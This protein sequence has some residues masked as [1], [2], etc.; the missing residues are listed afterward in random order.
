MC[1]IVGGISLSTSDTSRWRD[2][3]DEARRSLA[4]RGPD[5]HGQF[6]EGPVAMAHN[7]LKIIDLSEGGA[8]PMHDPTGRYVLAFNGEVFNYRELRRELEQGGVQFT[9][10]SDTEVMLALLIREGIAALPKF[11]G[12][13][14]LAF[15]DRHTR[16]LVLA[17]DPYGIKPLVLYQ[18]AEHLL[19]ASELK[20]LVELGIPRALDLTALALYTQ[21]N[22]VPPQSAMLQGVRKLNPGTALTIADVQLTETR[23]YTL[24]TSAAPERIP[25]YATATKEVRRRVEAAV[26]RRMISDV[27]VGVFLS[28]GLDSSI[29]AAV[30]AR[31]TEHLATFSLGFTDPV[32][33]ES[34]YARQVA[35]HLGTEHTVLTVTRDTLLE[36][37][38]PVLDYLDEPFADAAA[39]NFY[40]LS[41]YV[42][43]HVTVALTG[44]G[45]DEIF[46][47]YAK[48]VGESW[49][50]DHSTLA[51]GL[52][53]LSG[54]LRH[55]PGERNSQLGRRMAQVQKLADACTRSPAERYWAW[56]CTGTDVSDLLLHPPSLRQLAAYK[57]PYLAHFD[58]D[59]SMNAVYAADAH[60][61]L[62]G[63]MLPKA[64][65]MSM[66]NSLEVRP[67]FLDT[68]VVDYA[69]QLP[70]YYKLQGQ[71][72]KR[73][74]ADAFGGTLP[75][76]IT[77]RRKQGFEVPLAEWFRTSLRTRIE[78]ELIEPEFLH[79]QNLFEPAAVHRLW[80]AVLTG[81][82]RKE[83]WT[84][85]ALLVFQSFYRR[86]LLS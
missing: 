46:G 13:F 60:L 4:L 15:Y 86:Y 20:A 38:D 39:L 66:A 44:D 65:L 1:G 32:Y 74:L 49:V 70:P 31:H 33:D 80:Q 73:I 57:A 83:D 51:R 36:H 75:A 17:R 48:H 68:E 71:R 11:N 63:D 67:P 7:R 35:A 18:N 61:V 10:S 19:F 26:A 47:G 3:L 85:W 77:A 55:L 30:A 62:G 76:G 6:V 34:A 25:D 29:V 41:R 81:R 64:D 58:A 23:Y 42:K 21:L 69:M 28:G 24:R 2:Q 40:V 56:A 79:A 84:L 37:L 9:S 14:A 72:R 82:N 22:Y 12:F 43:P 8:Q 16:K 53:A 50:R 45:A 59:A 27:P 54:L 52:G 78:R 5:A